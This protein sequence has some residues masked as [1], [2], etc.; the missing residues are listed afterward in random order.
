MAGQLVTS[1]GI[2]FRVRDPFTSQ[3]VSWRRGVDEAVMR[4][5]LGRSSQ[6][7]VFGLRDQGLTNITEMPARGE[8]MPYYGVIGGGFEFVLHPAGELTEVTVEA[9]V[10][11]HPMFHPDPIEPLRLAIPAAMHTQA[12][13]LENIGTVAPNDATTY[14]PE[15]LF[16]FYGQF[17]DIFHGWEWYSEDAG[18]YD[19][20][21]VPTSVGTMVSIRH[22]ESESL[23]DLTRDVQW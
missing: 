4:Y 19:F 3:I 21:F 14:L 6:I 20:I 8:F 23:L 2:F 9:A 5:Q 18:K 15:F 11:Q 13:V 10:S 12:E 17:I 1:R 22:R 7:L 16:G